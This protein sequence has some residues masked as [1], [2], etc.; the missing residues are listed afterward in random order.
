[1]LTGEDWY[2]IMFD[3]TRE[4]SD[5]CIPNVS[6]GSSILSLNRILHHFLYLFYDFYEI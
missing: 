3:T 4:P 1:M 5:G 2:R 6:C